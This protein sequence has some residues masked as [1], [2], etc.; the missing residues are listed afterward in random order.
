MASLNLYG[1]C[2]YCNVLLKN[3]TSTYLIES[4]KDNLTDNPFKD[5]VWDDDT[6]IAANFKNNSLSGSNFAGSY[7][8]VSYFKIY[9]TFSN[10]PKL[11]E[12]F[13]TANAN[14]G[15]IEDFTVGSACPY[16]YYIYPICQDENGNETIGSII[17]SNPVELNDGIVR[18][19]GLIQDEKDLDKYY[20]DLD[21]IWHF[22]L[23]ISNTGFTNNM[24]KTYNDTLHQYQKEV[25][26]NGNYRTFTVEGLLGKYDCEKHDY[27]DTYDD[28][29]E[30]EKFMN[31]D[32]LKMAI[33]LRGIVSLGS[34]ESNSFQ[35]D[36]V[37]AQDVAVSFA[38]RQ[39]EDLDHVT[40]IN[41]QLPTNPTDTRVL[42]D[43]NNIALQATADSN[44]E[45]N[46]YLVV[47]E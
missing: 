42:V 14:I 36:E 22:S 17:E 41:N 44:N 28:I 11:H 16:T 40:V 29:I 20:I 46:P 24:A 35:Y 2:A 26:G 1:G 10:Q 43:S 33:D 7:G 8:N 38:F 27:I 15:V 5:Y 23:N 32:Q 31:N 25:K 47:K 39:L 13:T 21:N 9:K 37:G 3:S 45:T 18:I 6:V 34:I 30:W 4:E 19:I 12:V